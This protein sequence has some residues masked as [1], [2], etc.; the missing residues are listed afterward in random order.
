VSTQNLNSIIWEA[1]VTSYNLPSASPVLN[2]GYNF[3][4]G[5]PEREWGR[6]QCHLGRSNIRRAKGFCHSVSS[7]C[8]RRS[9]RLQC[10]IEP[11]CPSRFSVLCTM[12]GTR[13]NMRWKKQ[14]SNLVIKME[15]IKWVWCHFFSLPA[16]M[17]LGI[18]ES[19]W[20]RFYAK[21]IDLNN[22]FSFPI[23]LLIL[24]MSWQNQ[25]KNGKKC[26]E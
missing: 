24:R 17:E 26:V 4:S 25:G 2:G 16:V 3:F 21:T 6:G 19:T 12:G 8:T 1:V 10:P 14:K 5:L 9:K 20:C 7:M 22:H 11:Q 15:N 23:L 13:S 18:A